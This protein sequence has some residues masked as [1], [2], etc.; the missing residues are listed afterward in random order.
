MTRLDPNPVVMVVDD[1]ESVRKLARR[2][3]ETQGYEVADAPSGA[4]ALRILDD[5]S[6]CDLLMA[7]LQMPGM[8]GD[9]MARRF[10]AARPDLKVLY[11]T[12][13]IDLLFERRQFLWDHEAFLDKPFTAG[14]LTEAVSLLLYGRLQA[15][16]ASEQN[17]ASEEKKEDVPRLVA[18]R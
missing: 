4:D 2:I 10:R 8:P 11:V 7:D 15:G 9:E 6:R 3:L 14:S 18:R 12:G 16:P 1:E 5:G 17:L 13:F